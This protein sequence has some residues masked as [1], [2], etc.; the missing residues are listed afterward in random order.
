MSHTRRGRLHHLELYVGELE[1]SL[2][3]WGWLLEELGYRPYQE[4]D[5]GLS[6]CHHDVYLSLVQAPDRSA[7]FD[8]RR[9]GLNH[10]AFHVD[11]AAEVDRLTGALVAR[12]ARL[13]YPDRHPHAGGPDHYAAFFAD[14]D[15]LKV[16]LVGDDRTRDQPPPAGRPED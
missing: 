11:T 16:E 4:W 9:V 6:W 5:D 1:R 15:G 3:F 10:V 13:L 2:G 12:G 8:R 14:P 7:S